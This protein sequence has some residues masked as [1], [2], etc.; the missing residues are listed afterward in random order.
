MQRPKSIRLISIRSKNHQH[1]TVS[2][3]IFSLKQ[4][5]KNRVQ[6]LSHK[7]FLVEKIEVK[8]LWV[9]SKKMM[10]KICLDKNILGKKK[11]MSKTNVETK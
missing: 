8:I 2:V 7:Q 3:V 4:P 1:C 10:P 11:N 9:T 5:K 6:K